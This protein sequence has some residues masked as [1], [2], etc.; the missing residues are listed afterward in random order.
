MVNKYSKSKDGRKQLSKNFMVREFACKCSRCSTVQIDDK[1]VGYLQ[2][3]RDHFGKA[4][5]ITSG[6]RC[7]KHNAEV[8][9]ASGSRHVMGQAA[10]F[11]ISGVKPA[12]VAKFAESIGV[13]GIG[14]YEKAD[15]GDDFVHIDT[16]SA[17]SF[18]YGHK[19]AYRSTFGGSPEPAKPETCKVALPVLMKGSKGASVKALQVM[20]TGY[21]YSCGKGGADGLFG[22]ATDTALRAYQKAKGLGVDGICGAKTWA[23]LLGA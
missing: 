22:A 15:C 19:Q 3:I 5:I 6:Y 20:L 12:E 16:R 4:L 8:G 18:W 14:L 11:Y 23:S 10:D 9:G 17:K 2:Q 1:L 7:E 13:K 21:G